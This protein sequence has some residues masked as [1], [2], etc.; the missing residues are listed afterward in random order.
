MESFRIE[1]IVT[2]ICC[3]VLVLGLYA[4]SDSYYSMLG[5]VLLMNMNYPKR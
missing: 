1:N 2:M 3:T 4:L 5:L